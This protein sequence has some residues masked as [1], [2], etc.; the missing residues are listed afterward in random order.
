MQAIPDFKTLPS[1]KELHAVLLSI[2]F[3]RKR[4]DTASRFKKAWEPARDAALSRAKELLSSPS[5]LKLPDFDRE[6]V[7]HI[8]ASEEG[9]GAFLA[10]PSTFSFSRQDV[11][12]VA[13][14]SQRFESGQRH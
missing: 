8:D 3:T 11:D 4:H 9:V 14:C 10:Q 6:F 12:I 13:Y 2:T 1:L 5:A 7:V